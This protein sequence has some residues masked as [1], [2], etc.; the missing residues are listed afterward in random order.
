MVIDLG[1][2]LFQKEE[3]LAMCS[4]IYVPELEFPETMI[5]LENFLG[6][7]EKKGFLE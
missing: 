1:N 3:L 4:R 5:R 7:L 6:W 2:S